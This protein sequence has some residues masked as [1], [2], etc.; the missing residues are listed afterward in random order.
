[1]YLAQHLVVLNFIH[2]VGIDLS[3]QGVLVVLATDVDEQ[4]GRAGV[5]VATESDVTDVTGH[6]D[7][8]TQ[9]HS[10]QYAW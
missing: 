7:A 2:L 6:V 1:M 8:I 9:D 4:R 5:D 3:L 10:D